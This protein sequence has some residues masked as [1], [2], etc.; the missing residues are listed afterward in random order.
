MSDTEDLN[1]EKP[2]LSAAEASRLILT[3]LYEVMASR[4]SAQ[5]KLNHIVEIIGDT[6]SSEVCSIYLLREGVLELYATR[7]LNQDAVHV[8]KLAFGE[9]LTGTIAKNIETLN[10]DE[11]ASHP[12][13][14]YRPETGEEKFHSFAGVPIIRLEHAVGVI[15]VQHVEPRCYDDVEIEA[16]QT[17]AMILSELIANADLI[18]SD[19]LEF[20]DPKLS[21]M[22]HL[23]GLT[24]VKGLAMGRA[25]FHN[26]RIAIDH[27]VAEDTE[28]ERERVY[29]AFERMREQ[30]DNMASQMEFGRGGE[31]T[32]IL[33]TYKIFAY[34][35]GWSRRINAAIDSGLTAE[36]A[37]ERVQQHTRMRMRQID[38]P[39]LAERMHDLEDLSNRLLRIVSGKMGTAAQMALPDDTILL[40][41]NLAGRINGI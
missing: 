26:P 23:P 17:V 7:G 16:L 28:K 3:G 8:T 25:V 29:T 14:Q 35:E 2:I 13:F 37:I 22:R 6:L 15:C 32:E 5:A 20:S 9:G 21:G 31:I 30:I 4:Q 24:L 10:L 34:D 40:A 36:A 11:A 38:D 39:L 27:V 12:N 18:D 19:M 1:R 41:R 33:D